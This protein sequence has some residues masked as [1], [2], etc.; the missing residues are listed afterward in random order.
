[1]IHYIDDTY[2]H[3]GPNDELY[4]DKRAALYTLLA[5]CKEHNGGQLPQIFAKSEVGE[6][7]AARWLEGTNTAPYE[8]FDASWHKPIPE[9]PDQQILALLDRKGWDEEESKE[10][11]NRNYE[12]L[13]AWLQTNN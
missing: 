3:D 6:A 5:R 11:W 8:W 10:E 13:K 12:E 2:Y 4:A 7:I 1:M 9:D